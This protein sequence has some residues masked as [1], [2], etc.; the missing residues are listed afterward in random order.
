MYVLRAN[1]LCA[2]LREISITV[3]ILR[4]ILPHLKFF[5]SEKNTYKFHAVIQELLHTTK[6]QQ[7]PKSAPF[8][9]RSPQ[10]FRIENGPPETYYSSKQTPINLNSPNYFFENLKTEPV[11]SSQQGERLKTP[12][13]QARKSR[14]LKVF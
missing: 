8:N 3:R 11:N 13:N 14:F 9:F 6:R 10:S 12:S 7:P 4:N 5:C 1:G 2:Y